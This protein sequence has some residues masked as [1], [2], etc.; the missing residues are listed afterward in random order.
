MMVLSVR[1]VPLAYGPT[2]KFLARLE[3]QANLDKPIQITLPRMSFEMT[4]I[5]IMIHQERQVSLKPSSL[6]EDG[7][8]K[9]VYMPV[10]YNIGF[11]VSIFCKVK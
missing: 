4:S 11:S 7:N 6:Y 10:P 9:K 8:V 5:G 1:K 3:Q 2:Q